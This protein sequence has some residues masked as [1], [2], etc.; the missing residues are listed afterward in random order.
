MALAHRTHNLDAA[1]GILDRTMRLG[2]SHGGLI[3]KQRMQERSPE[4]TGRMVRSVY[5]SEVR[6]SE[7]GYEVRA[8]PTPDYSIYTELE[9][10]IIGKR[11]GPISQAKG[12]TI[13]WMK[14]AADDV[15]EE[16]VALLEGALHA[17]VMELQLRYRGMRL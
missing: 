11:P 9:P 10:W 4:L 8:G 14:P 2:L 7:D 1:L 17:T 13:P 3:L 16:V 5:V 12:A 15:R 6:H